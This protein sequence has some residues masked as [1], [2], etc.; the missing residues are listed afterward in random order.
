MKKYIFIIAI[1][2]LTISANNS[3]EYR[4]ILLSNIG[5]CV[6]CVYGPNDILTDLASKVDTT[7]IRIE[8]KINCRRDKEL[9]IFSRN[10]SWDFRLSRDTASKYRKY[11][12]NSNNDVIILNSKD[13][14]IFSFYSLD[15]SVNADLIIKQIHEYEEAMK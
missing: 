6:K 9:K 2:V 14:L 5:A 10:Y 8:A 13:S 1:F 12:P 3:P 4:V 15:K 7:K 11:S